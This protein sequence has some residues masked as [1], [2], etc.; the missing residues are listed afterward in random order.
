[1]NDLVYH[2]HDASDAFRIKLAGALAGDSVRD[3]GQTWRTAS[4]VIGQ[5]SLVVDLSSV[6]GIDRLGREL[7]ESWRVQG[8]SM[9][10]ATSADKRRIESMVDLPVTLVPTVP[11]ANS[12]RL[13][14]LL[15]AL[16]CGY[17]RS[18]VIGLTR[19]A[20]RAGT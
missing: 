9:I 18:A 7:L 12:S 10:V 2:I 6:T 19:V 16:R 3:V 15:S 5:R 4:S 11:E 8:A 17:S 13:S 1:M 20:R 14:L